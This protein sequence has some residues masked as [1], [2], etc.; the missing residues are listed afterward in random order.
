[1]A[2]IAIGQIISSL[3]PGQFAR[4][5]KIVPSGS[6]EARKLSSGGTM[7]Y[8][9]MTVKGKSLREPIGPYD[10]GL[11]DADRKLT[12]GGAA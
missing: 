9:R 8:W 12:I 7:L 1:M 2:V 3:Q 4:L 10:V 11:V 5:A 6:L